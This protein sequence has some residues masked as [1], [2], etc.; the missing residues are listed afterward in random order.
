[1][2]RTAASILILFVLAIA[3]TAHA[4]MVSPDQYAPCRSPLACSTTEGGGRAQG[5]GG[6][7]STAAGGGLSSS[8]GGGLSTGPGG[9]M[10]SGPGGGLYAGPGGGMSS[11]PGGGLASDG[12]YKGP[13]SPCLTGVLGAD[14]NRL[15]CPRG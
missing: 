12:R 1:M 10:S 5:A 6:G 3:A 11:G 8:A 9:G 13:W 14:W 4:Q 2:S 15:H 7:L